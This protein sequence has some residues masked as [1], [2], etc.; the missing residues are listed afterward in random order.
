LLKVMVNELRPGLRL[1]KSVIAADGRVLLFAGTELK[2][3]YIRH[4]QRMNVA[5]VYVQNELAPDIEPEDVVAGKTRQALS[6]GMK[7]A[8]AEISRSVQEAV[9]KG[10]R[11]YSVQFP[12]AQLKAAVNSVVDDLLTNP[13]AVVNLQD[14]RTAD[15]YTLGHSVNV[16][17]TAVM[18]GV[19]M[20]YNAAQLGELGMGALMHDVGKVAIPP[21]IL[22]KPDRL[23]AEEFAIMSRHTTI[24]WEILSA[25]SEISY[26]SAAVAL[27]HHERWKGG[28]YPRSIAGE[29]I[30]EYARVCAVADCYD[31]MTADR[32]YR[33]GFVPER[34]LKIMTELTADYYEPQVLRTFWECIALYPVGSMIEITGGYM[35]V[36]VGNERGRTDRPRVRIVLDAA[37]RPVPRPVEVDL[38]E[39]REIEIVRT[40][41]DEA[42]EFAPDLIS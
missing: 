17:I 40:V 20:G 2:E 29:Q 22:N 1:G 12:T 32:I 10:S 27:Q 42:Y 11:R 18:L 34:A 15:E 14:I 13:R 28:G 5:A 37:G 39:R 23:T 24:G 4:L 38:N 7:E 21:E 3:S 6:A 31:A 33:K 9:A 25:Q 19:S 26:V 35:A 16:C 30:H 36:V 8:V 41:R